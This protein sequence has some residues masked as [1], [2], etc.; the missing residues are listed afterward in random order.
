[1]LKKTVAG[2]ILQEAMLRSVPEDTMQI[3]L[4]KGEETGLRQV[5]NSGSLRQRAQAAKIL[6]DFD[7]PTVYKRI[8]QIPSELLTAADI[9]LLKQDPV[10]I[11]DIAQFGNRRS[12][13]LALAALVA[14][15]AS[16]SDFL[17]LYNLF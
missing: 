14:L 16:N 13:R 4:L 5:A 17:D 3:L 2:S 7:I 12:R 8:R 9:W 11:L 1:M 6:R 10:E 15:S